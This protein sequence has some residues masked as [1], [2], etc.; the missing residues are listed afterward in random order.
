MQLFGGYFRERV[1]EWGEKLA[2]VTNSNVIKTSPHL[3][4][5]LLSHSNWFL[6]AVVVIWQQRKELPWSHVTYVFY[7]VYPSW[8]KWHTVHFN[9]TEIRHLCLTYI[10]R[11]LKPWFNIDFSKCRQH[12]RPGIVALLI[13]LQS[14]SDRYFFLAVSSKHLEAWCRKLHSVFWE[15]TGCDR[16]E[17]VRVFGCVWK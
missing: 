12:T 7:F 2:N 8:Q 9:L 14:W 6:S 15:S 17:R 10:E 1:R 3:L 4:I 5:L 16:A 11:L 13:K